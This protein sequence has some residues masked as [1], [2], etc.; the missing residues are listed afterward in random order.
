VRVEPNRVLAFSTG[1][2]LTLLVLTAG[3]FG[4]PDF[5]IRY[6][7][8]AIGFSACYVA[9]NSWI[10][11]KAAAP[12]APLIPDRVI[13]L[14]F[15]VVIPLVILIFAAVPVFLPG[16]DFALLVIIATVFFG[17]TVRS[18]MRVRRDVAA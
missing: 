3:V 13:G 15:A 12:P 6:A 10:E 18:A 2:A 8:I 7:L 11:R 5:Q 4:R 16:R 14:P 9:L 1:L 17:L